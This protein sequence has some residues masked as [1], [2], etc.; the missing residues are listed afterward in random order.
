[1][2]L[3]TIKRIMNRIELQETKLIGLALKGKTSNENEQAATDCGNLWQ[4]FEKGAYAELIPGKLSDEIIAV[5]HEYEGDHTKPY[6][7][8]IGCRVSADTAVP[9]GLQSLSLAKGE[10]RKIIAT[11][12]MPDCVANS[13]REIWSSNMQRGYRTDFEVYG[14]KSKDWNNAEVEIY[15]SI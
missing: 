10:Y 6:S 4:E 12:K 1:M 5:Y 11:G 15:V 8:F 13:W 2:E 3:K 9:E 14:E 7:Y